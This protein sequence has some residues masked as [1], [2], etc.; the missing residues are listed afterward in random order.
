MT[1]LVLALTFIICTYNFISKLLD[2]SK[3]MNI[4]PCGGQG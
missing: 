1:P 4:E 2:H 3:N